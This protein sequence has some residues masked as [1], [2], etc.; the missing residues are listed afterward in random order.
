MIDSP[1]TVSIGVQVTLVASEPQNPVF[2]LQYGIVVIVTPPI[3][4]KFTVLQALP[5][6][7]FTPFKPCP[8]AVQ[9]TLSRV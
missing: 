8:D 7:R 5:S 3:V 2:D 6:N 1:R 9:I 4:L